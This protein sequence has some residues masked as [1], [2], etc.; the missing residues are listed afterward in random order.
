M[1]T[2]AQDDREK[3]YELAKEVRIAM[4]TTLESDGSLHV[5]PMGNREADEQG[6]FWFFAAKDESVAKNIAANP[7]VAL[8]FSDPRGNTYV[9]ISGTA[10]LNDSRAMIEEL[11]TPYLEAWFPKGKTDPNIVLIKVDP[12]RGEFWDSSA[13]IIVNA[14]GFIKAKLGG[15]AANDL[16]DTKK[17]L[18]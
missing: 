2:M 16:G 9:S 15:G 7:Q 12:Q 8:G 4:M 13:S 3:L 10:E 11:W 14:I 5:R 17:L 18:L 6:N 1:G